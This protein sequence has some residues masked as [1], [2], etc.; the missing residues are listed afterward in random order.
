MFG[1][2]TGDAKASPAKHALKNKNCF[3]LESEFPQQTHAIRFRDSP[4]T[5]EDMVSASTQMHKRLK[6]HR[7]KRLRGVI[8]LVCFCVVMWVGYGTHGY[9]KFKKEE[10]LW[11]GV[12]A[13]LNPTALT[14]LC[15][16]RLKSASL[17]PLVLCAVLCTTLNSK[18]MYDSVSI[19]GSPLFERYI[20]AALVYWGGCLVHL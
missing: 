18:A 7:E 16:V 5:Y 4:F 12:V 15:M 13:F 8:F 20:I 9:G 1:G 14:I 10:E 2:A 17:Y 6:Q 3:A 11:L 19:D